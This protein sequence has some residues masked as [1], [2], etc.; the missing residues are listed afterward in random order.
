MTAV[1]QIRKLDSLPE[2][3]TVGGFVIE[4]DIPPPYV[5]APKGALQEALLALEVGESLVHT[6]DGSDTRKKARRQRPGISFA[7]KEIAKSAGRKKV[8]SFPTSRLVDAA[9]V[10][11]LGR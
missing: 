3:K 7:V 8:V 9:V 2:V 6:S 10:G 4:R 11:V 1:R 5:R